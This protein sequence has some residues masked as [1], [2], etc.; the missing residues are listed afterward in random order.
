M[1]VR[2]DVAHAGVGGGERFQFMAW[3][4]ANADFF[5]V[6]TTI[7]QVRPPNEEPFQPPQAP[8]PKLQW[9]QNSTS[10]A[11]PLTRVNGDEL[12]VYALPTEEPS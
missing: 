5:R 1:L 12:L 4:A 11:I 8:N 2:G 9:F 7:V 3:S 10:S 6:D